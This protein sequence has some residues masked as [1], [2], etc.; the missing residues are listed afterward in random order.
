MPKAKG[1]SN[2]S[3]FFNKNKNRWVVQSYY[4]DAITDKK[5]TKNKLFKT[6]EEAK[7]YL[8]VVHLQKE[9]ANYVKDNGIHLIDLMRARVNKKLAMNL[10]SEN[11]Y[12]RTEMTLKMI[13]KSYLAETK[14]ENIT[15]EQIQN[16]FNSLTDHYSN[17]SIKKFHEQFKQAFE[18]A[19]NKGYLLKNPMKDF[20]KPK[21]KKKDKVVRALTIEEQQAFTEYLLNKNLEEY[22]YRNAFLIQMYMGLRIGEVMALKKGDIDIRNNLIRVSRTITTGK[23]SKAVLGDSTKTYAGRREVP[24]P[25]YILP[26]VVEQLNECK[27]HK[28]NML[29]ESKEGTIID[30]R[31]V[32][33]ILKNSLKELGIEGISTHSLRHTYGT[34]NVE[35]GMRAVALQR[36]MGHKDIS[37][38]LNTYTSVF[39]KFKES[40][41]EK[42][43]DY[44]LSNNFFQLPTESLP[45]SNQDEIELNDYEEIEE[46]LNSDKEEKSNDEKEK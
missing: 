27:K 32:N 7:R 37:V 9:D 3:I 30:P 40:E 29:F 23:N 41:M 18:Y 42:V 13:E 20:I 34:R 39:N 8:D 1:T 16:Y 44:Y 22:K 38:T 25:K 36:L 46:D 35:A 33:I 17:S 31:N 14:I 45:E 10:I 4:I 43:N 2:G 5:K 28:D 11:Q 24:I 21:S 19:E 15:T 12:Y 26:Y 6:E